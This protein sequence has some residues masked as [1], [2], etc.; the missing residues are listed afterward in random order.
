MDS[1]TDEARVMPNCLKNAPLVP[2]ENIT[3]MNTA[4]NTS[5][6][7]I[8]AMVTSDKALVVALTTFFSPSCSFVITASVTTMASSTTVPMAS[9]SAKSVRRFREKPASFTMAKVPIR[10]TIMEMDGM[11]VALKSCR[12]KNTTRMTRRMARIRVS[13]TLCMAASRK[14]SLHRRVENLR[15]A[16]AI[17]SASLS[18]SLIS[19]FTALALAPGAWYTMVMTAGPSAPLEVKV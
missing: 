1:P 12:K 4:I 14:S 6:V 3:G 8:A 19:A 11:R 5:V 17:C 16:G 7:E 2:G 10:D 18:T 15:P 13:T 9:T